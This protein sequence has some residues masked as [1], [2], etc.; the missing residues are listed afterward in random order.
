[1]WIEI[2][3]PNSVPPPIDITPAPARKYEL[4]VI[5]YNTSGVVMAEKNIFGQKMTDIFVKG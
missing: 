3:D 4:R 5:V 2:F 1:M